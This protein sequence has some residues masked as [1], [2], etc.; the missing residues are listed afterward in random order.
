MMDRR[1]SN[2]WQ[3]GWQS[4]LK[5]EGAQ[6]HCNCIVRDINFK[7]LNICSAIRFPRD[8]FLKL[9]LELCDDLCLDIEA[10]V[11]WHRTVESKNIY[12]LYFTRIKDPDKES[13]YQFIGK[14]FP[15]QLYAQVWKG[16][17]QEGGGTMQEEKFEDRRIFERFETK[18]PL[19]FIDLTSSKEGEADLQD[20][21]AKGIGFVSQQELLPQSTVEMWL[22]VPDKGE[23]LYVRGKVV[24]SKAAES[25]RYRMGVNLERA[26]LMGLARILRIDM[27]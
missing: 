12:G 19:R 13:I 23:P 15:K 8:T 7:G 5:L 24:W 18:M 11:A 25:S 10:W 22:K 2:R 26:D 21:C 14:N 1:R 6:N 16:L 27:D 3:I 9:S 20:V 4:K 17:R